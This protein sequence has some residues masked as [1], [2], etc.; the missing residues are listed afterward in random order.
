MLTIKK[1]RFKNFL[2]YGGAWNEIDFDNCQLS[3]VQSG[4]GQGKTSIIQAVTFGLYNRSINNIPKNKL[5][6]S[7][8]GK[9][10]VVEVE[11][12]SNN[13]D[14]KVIRGIKP[15]VFQIYKDD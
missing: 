7:I 1:V 3:V 15:N 9:Q 13:I 14:Y 11:F 10:T 8:N 12:T 6:N 5:V 4:N 2:S